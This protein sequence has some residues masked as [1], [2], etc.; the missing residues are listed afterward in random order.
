MDCCSL[1]Q[2]RGDELVVA[3]AAGWQ[4]LEEVVQ[5]SGGCGPAAMG[6]TRQ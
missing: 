2:R 4:L 3:P 5:Q 1:A 6:H